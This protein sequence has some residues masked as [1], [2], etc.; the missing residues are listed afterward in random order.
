M[1]RKIVCLVVI[2]IIMMG[3]TSSVSAK[4]M[5]V[6]DRQGNPILEAMPDIKE[7]HSADYN[8]NI[9]LTDY[10]QNYSIDVKAGFFDPV[11]KMLNRITNILFVIQRIFVESVIYLFH[12]ALQFSSYELFDVILKSFISGMYKTTFGITSSILISLLGIYF[13]IKMLQQR[14]VEFW[15]E[16]AKTIGIV[17][18]AT[19]YFT[20]PL[21]LANKVEEASNELTMMIVSSSNKEAI[22]NYKDAM[23]ANQERGYRPEK[24]TEIITV[25]ANNLWNE[26]VHRPWRLM[27]FG[28]ENIADEW[29]ERVL[30]TSIS[31]DQ[32]K[33]VIDELEKRTTIDTE[34]MTIKRLGFMIMYLIPL[35]INV[36]LMAIFCIAIIGLQFLVT[37]VFVLGVFIFIL[38]LVPSYGTQIIKKW[39][40]NILFLS[41]T[42]IVMA[43]LLMVMLTFN[44]ALYATAGE[45]GWLYTLLLQLTLYSMIYF[46]RHKIWGMFLI[47]KEILPNPQ[48]AVNRLM[49][50]GEL[51]SHSSYGKK[52]YS[53]I[54]PRSRIKRPSKTHP[55]SMEILSEKAVAGVKNYATEKKDA[56]ITKKNEISDQYKDKKE[57]EKSKKYLDKKYEHYK[58]KSGKMSP[59]AVEFT[60]EVDKR[61]QAGEVPYSNTQIDEVKARRKR[62]KE[63]V[64]KRN[65]RETSIEFKEEKNYKVIKRSNQR[66]FYIH[67]G[68]MMRKKIEK[69]EKLD[70]ERK[71]DEDK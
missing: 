17:A 60:N 38:A 56:I 55:R 41:G 49:K 64:E 48:R 1:I 7:V 69:W 65:T 58:K 14:Q 21:L 61:K 33:D 43:F 27:E 66:G 39:A 8:N 9:Y 35:I 23:E 40:F 62:A 18:V 2:L 46:F 71:K 34:S 30:Q 11:D 59:K 44:S 29:Q 36:L 67:G 15:T 63:Y 37:L 70:K 42:K 47:A 57:S 54:V 12:E 31:S 6:E 5:I 68:R 3:L 20:N 16:L 24:N 22:T 10:R 32:R 52:S 28:D 25:V 26:Y 13:V 53:K 51:N 50:T 45:K 4:S 19:L